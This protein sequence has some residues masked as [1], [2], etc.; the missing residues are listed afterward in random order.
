ME[1]TLP[2][3]LT[4][5][6]NTI[7]ESITKTLLP[8]L[9]LIP[10]S[11]DS[12][13][14]VATLINSGQTESPGISIDN[15][16]TEHLNL[17]PISTT[18][19][20]PSKILS[21]DSEVSGHSKNSPLPTKSIRR[22]R[23]A[24]DAWNSNGFSYALR[25]PGRKFSG[26]VAAIIRPTNRGFLSP[27]GI[28][29][30]N[31][32]GRIATSARGLPS[33]NAAISFHPHDS[34]EHLHVFYYHYPNC[35]TTEY[36]RHLVRGGLGAKW[37]RVRYPPG[38]R[39]YVLQDREKQVLYDGTNGFGPTWDVQDGV[40]PVQDGGGQDTEEVRLQDLCEGDRP[41]NDSSG[42]DEDFSQVSTRQPAQK[43]SR[44]GPSPHE[45]VLQW[46]AKFV[47]PDKCTFEQ[48]LL[49]G[50]EGE[51]YSLKCQ[52]KVTQDFL[53]RQ[54]DLQKLKMKTMP[55]VEYI[56]KMHPI[57]LT[58]LN[59]GMQ[60]LEDSVMWFHKIMRH[61]GIRPGD[62]VQDVW[63]IM[64]S[65]IPKKN[66]AFW[67]GQSNAGKSLLS[68]SIAGSCCSVAL[69]NIGGK[70]ETL[71]FAFQGLR[72]AR[73]C[74]INEAL[75][76]TDT[77]ESYLPIFGGEPVQTDVKFG[78]AET[79]PRTPIIITTNKALG[80]DLQPHSKRT[81]LPA[82]QNRMTVYVFF[83]FD[84]LKDC[85]GS[86]NPLMWISLIQKYCMK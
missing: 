81:H 48:A 45:L 42:S 13:H 67:T 76:T 32:I 21:S 74:V 2:A 46:T 4:V 43:R 75:I 38:M 14:T 8:D 59:P 84:E 41:D 6:E 51:V 65:R 53:T 79:I 55:W 56:L 52:S 69:Q 28:N 35:T 57:V 58:T 62:F 33:K 27:R 7:H 47:A 34:G 63:D 23:D 71:R 22:R 20:E 64:D 68:N 86:L 9:P 54:L 29:I 3:V 40:Q 30:A 80:Q 12:E 60:S 37:I 18:Q 85:K 83:S 15:W 25:P 66:C 77:L 11:Q 24:A 26:Y 49:Q 44:A 5:P 70:P 10:N 72:N 78:G 1:V 31:R 36:I 17:F 19:P 16:L 50:K 73:C 39:N 61:N 82:L